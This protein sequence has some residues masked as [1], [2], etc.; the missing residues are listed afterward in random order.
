MQQQKSQREGTMNFFALSFKSMIY[1]K[2]YT[3]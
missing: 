3:E 2:I 1:T